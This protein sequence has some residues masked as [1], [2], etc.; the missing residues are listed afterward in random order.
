[1]TSRYLQTMIIRKPGV[2][3][4]PLLDG[5]KAVVGSIVGVIP[6][7]GHVPAQELNVTVVVQGAQVA[8]G[9]RTKGH[10]V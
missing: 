2:I 10:G 1:M 6:W 7:A 3:S 9:P 4:G 8:R 5:Q